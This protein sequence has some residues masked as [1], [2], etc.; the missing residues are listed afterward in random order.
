MSVACHRSHHPS[1]TLSLLVVL[2]AVPVAHAQFLSDS[3]GLVNRLDIRAGGQTFEMIVTSNFDI[4]DYSFDADQ[5]RLVMHTGSSI[6][7][8][9]GEMIIPKDLL[10]GDLTFYLDGIAHNVTTRSNN[11]ITLLV[12]DF[13]G[14]STGHTIE[15]LGTE[16]FVPA[17]AG[18]V[19]PSDTA[20]QVRDLSKQEEV[21]KDDVADAAGGCLVATAAFGS[22][23]NYHVQHLR[24]VR[25]VK[26]AGTASGKA[27]LGVFNAVY[28]SFSPGV[29]DY[30]RENPIFRDAVMLFVMPMLVSL[31]LLNYAETGS[32][33][34]VLGYG[35]ILIGLNLCMYVVA[36]AMLVKYGLNAMR[37][38]LH[39][40]AA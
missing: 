1:V 35:M 8:S 10:S 15:I 29:A 27:F 23:M 38:L 7:E 40:H 13:A 2:C 39:G 30:E 37:N 19:R 16:T 4:V 12:V 9:M 21:R 33:A 32:E 20:P 25:D 28:Y 22:E 34:H 5:V 3:T 14:G 31:S 6:S 17:S 11:E 18:D 24:E 36:P 26:L